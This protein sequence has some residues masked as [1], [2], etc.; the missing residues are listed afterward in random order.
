MTNK[1]V[2]LLGVVTALASVLLSPTLAVAASD[3][4]CL[5][6]P[7]CSVITSGSGT[8]TVDAVSFTTD[9]ISGTVT[10]PVFSNESG[11]GQPAAFPPAREFAL[12]GGGTQA[13]L[14]V[15]YS[16]DFPAGEIT[17][18][19]KYSAPFVFDAFSTPV[20]GPTVSAHGD[21]TVW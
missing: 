10:F 3:P 5:F 12:V 16:A 6:G 9:V 19:G 8:I 18:S 13:P 2:F 4:N 11:L 20:G 15:H 21:G 14:E 7:P 17:H 1:P